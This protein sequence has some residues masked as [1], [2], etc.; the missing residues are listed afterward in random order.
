M[1]QV[2][3][4]LVPPVKPF[5]KFPKSSKELGDGLSKRMVGLED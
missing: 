4:Y 3:P 2:V 1:T 5:K